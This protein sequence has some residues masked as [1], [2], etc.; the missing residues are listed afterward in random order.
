MVRMMM[1]DRKTGDQNFKATMQDFVRTYAGRAA[2]TEDFK[3]V[4]EKHMMPE[5]AAFGGGTIFSMN[6]SRGRRYRATASSLL[7]I[8][9][10]AA[11]GR[12]VS[13]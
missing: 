9:M 5:M 6:T 11:M 12:L 4:V 10:P 2:T 8:T 7:S 3:A 1:W 13:S